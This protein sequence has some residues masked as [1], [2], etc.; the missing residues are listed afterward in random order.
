MNQPII[1][2]VAPIFRETGHQQLG[3]SGSAVLIDGPNGSPWLVSAAHVL[4]EMDHAQIV[5][6]AVAGAYYYLVAEGKILSTCELTPLEAAQ[7]QKDL[8]FVRLHPTIAESLRRA[9]FKFL[10]LEQIDLGESRPLAEPCIL[11]GYPRQFVEMDEGRPRHLLEMRT[12]SVLLPDAD[13]AKRFKLKADLHLVSPFT[14]LRDETGKPMKTP[15]PDGMSG[16]A[17]WTLWP[18]GNRLAGIIIEHDRHRRE[19]VGSRIGPLVRELR[20]RASSPKASP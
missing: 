1:R 6:A 15:D 8:A 18:E 12:K 17:I 3:F 16:G 9:D 7:D 11:D 2:H 20:R 13:V 19:I 10:S 5:V 4:A 14:A